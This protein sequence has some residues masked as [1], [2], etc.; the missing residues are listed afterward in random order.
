MPIQSPKLAYNSACNRNDQ[1]HEWLGVV[2]VASFRMAVYSS[3]GNMPCSVSC[4]DG[5]LQGIAWIE[6]GLSLRSIPTPSGACFCP[7]VEFVDGLGAS[8]MSSGSRVRRRAVSDGLSLSVPDNSS[9]SSSQSK[10]TGSSTTPA[11]PAQDILVRGP[12]RKEVCNSVS[13]IPKIRSI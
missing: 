9:S 11:Q 3:V 12:R 4:L 6:S 1:P 5:S 8:G 2:Q 7:N 10:S 13:P